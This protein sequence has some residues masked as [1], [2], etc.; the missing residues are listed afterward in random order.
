MTY[1]TENIKSLVLMRGILESI[2]NGIITLQCVDK[3]LLNSTLLEAR[4]QRLLD[5][6]IV[7][8]KVTWY[9]RVVHAGK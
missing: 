9:A 3:M 8:E 7:V 2:Y 1:E 4:I 6:L 5:G